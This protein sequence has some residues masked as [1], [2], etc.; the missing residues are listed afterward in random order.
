[1]KVLIYGIN[2]APELTGIGK[3]SGEMGAWLANNKHEVEVIT[4]PPYY[5]EW[6]VHSSYQ[7]KGWSS[8]VIQG[9]K[10]SRAPLYVPNKVTSLT[11][12]IHEFSFV[13]ASFPYWL[14]AI[15]RKRHDVVI[16]VAPAF[17]LAFL[18]LLY[19]KLRKVPLIYHI[20]DLQIDAAK[21][22]GMIK[23]KNL[24]SILFKA[25]KFI[26]NHSTRVSTISEGMLGRVIL[27][28]VDSEKCI[29]FP[30]WVDENYVKP[31]SKAN[32]L[33]S[34]FGLKQT[35]KVV[36]Y[37]GALGEKQGLELIIEVA[38]SLRLHNNLYFL[39]IGSG[40]A[41]YKLEEMIS[42]YQLTNVKLLPLQPYEKL[43]A[44][45]ASAD[46]HLVLQKKSASDLVMPSKLTSIL[47]AGGC[48]VVTALPDT[49]LYEVVNNHKFGILVEPESAEALSTAIKNALDS[50]L[51][52]YR[53]NARVYAEKYLSK[54]GI[55]KEFEQT[56]RF[57]TNSSEQTTVIYESTPNLIIQPAVPVPTLSDTN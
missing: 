11:R 38:N 15:F 27:K 56:V 12:M 47:A 6:Q 36:M 22:L 29:L 18:A 41:K 10:V 13:A 5:P 30:N 8:Q 48:P 49:T 43:S 3:Y 28:G 23:N 45:L 25:E 7:R 52:V 9:V 19:S 44:M 1:M 32:S 53:S 50:D 31:V 57:L 37:S 35:D 55:L 21:D 20:Q 17:H 4:A 34:T 16:C 33:R 54:E 24:L 42:H 26:L 14:K 51:D 39:I 2:Y 46:L 40:G